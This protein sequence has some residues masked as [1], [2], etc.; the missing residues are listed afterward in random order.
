MKNK[1]STLI[2][3]APELSEDEDWEPAEEMTEEEVER[4]ERQIEETLRTGASPLLDALLPGK[5][6]HEEELLEIY[7]LE[8]ERR[9]RL[10]S[11][12]PTDGDEADAFWRHVERLFRRGQP[13]EQ[14]VRDWL[15]RES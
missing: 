9:L 2:T 5:D 14:C 6:W 8:V 1:S 15:V 3:N 4:I 12:V 10:K 11:L 7:R 13:E